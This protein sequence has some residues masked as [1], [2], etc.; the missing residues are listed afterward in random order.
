MK[1]TSPKS[2]FYSRLPVNVTPSRSMF[3]WMN[4]F[5]GWPCLWLRTARC[6]AV[7]VACENA[8]TCAIGKNS[9]TPPRDSSRLEGEKTHRFEE[10]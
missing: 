1:R 4:R 9:S 2:L 7:E 10:S 6:H 8:R 3:Q 5:S